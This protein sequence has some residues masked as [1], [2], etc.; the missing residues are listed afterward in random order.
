MNTRFK[1]ISTLSLIMA[2]LCVSCLVEDETVGLDNVP[3]NPT[4][5]VI[6]A[7]TRLA[8]TSLNPAGVVSCWLLDSDIERTRQT[9]FKDAMM[10]MGVKYIRYPY[11]ELAD[12]YLWDADGEYGGTLTPKVAN[13]G[14][15]PGTF[16]TSEGVYWA[17]DTATMEFK[18]DMDFDE[19][20]AVCKELG[21]EPMVVVN[22]GSYKQNNPTVTKDSLLTS[23]V[24]WVRYSNI[25]KGYNVK[26][27][28]LGNEVDHQNEFTQIEYIELYKEFA[29]A[30]KE[31]DPTIMVGP[32][33]LNKWHAPLLEE[34]GNL[35]D[36]VCVHN[37][38]FSYTWTTEGYEGWRDTEDTGINNV[39]AVQSVIA[40][41]AY[42]DLEIHVTEMNSRPWNTDPADDDDFFRSL[43][44]AE[45][46]LNSYRN[47]NVVATYC[48]NT[49]SPW[50]GPDV[51]V[52]YDLLDVNNKRKPRGE[53]IKLLNDHSL[54]WWVGA[55]RLVGDIRLY[56]SVS[57]DNQKMSVFLINKNTESRELSVDLNDFQA[58]GK[59]EVVSYVS[60]DANSTPDPY[61]KSPMVIEAGEDV[62][63]AVRKDH[64]SAEIP[65]LSL[66]I[67]SLN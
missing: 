48:W 34:A 53:V 1:M 36:F 47:K 57:D 25:T 42:P 4:A 10:D 61:S 49:H 54:D 12:N 11:G 60:G 67:I 8:N 33:L 16:K 63:K 59:F 27:W 28:A 15:A 38:L 45:M 41:S 6:N 44:L 46:T 39:D 58:N 40:A 7:G 65:P 24:E 13:V 32:G 22:V 5:V 29:A 19:Y 20:V 37:Y 35:V 3:K 52:E 18:N 26:R 9:T 43:V 50:S 14:Y 64:F 62:V 17:V 23:A 21:A 66:T 51:D 55:R 31:V 56:A 30:M 2:M